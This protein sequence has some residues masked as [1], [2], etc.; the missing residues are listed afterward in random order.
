MRKWMILLAAVLLGCKQY[1]SATAGSLRAQVQSAYAQTLTHQ[2][3]QAQ[4]AVAGLSNEE[5]HQ[6]FAEDYARPVSSITEITEENGGLMLKT[7]SGA[8]ITAM[9]D[10]TVA[11]AADVGW[12]YGYGKMALVQQ[13]DCYLMYAHCSQ[14]A[15]KTGDTVKQGD[16]IGEAG[17]TGHTEDGIRVG[18]YRF[19]LEDVALV[20]GADGTVSAFTVNG[21]VSGIGME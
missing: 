11:W 1:V 2:Y 9:K 16:K 21:E 5:F 18:V 14:V 6:S 20:T 15:V 17:D 7:D 12:N 3:P 13:E 8:S 4:P 19:P 10:G